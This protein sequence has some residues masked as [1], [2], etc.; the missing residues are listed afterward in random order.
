MDHTTGITVAGSTPSDRTPTGDWKRKNTFLSRCTEVYELKHWKPPALRAPVLILTIAICW[1][2]IAVLEYLLWKCQTDNGLIFAPVIN[3]LPLSDTFLYLYFPTIVAVIFSIYWAWIDLETKRMEPYYQLSKDNGAL[4]KDSLLLQYPFSFL[5]FVPMKAFR[6]R[7]WPVFW[8]SLA[9]VLVTWGLVPTQAGIFSVQTVTRSTNKTFAVSTY[10]MPFEEQATSLTFRYQQSTYGIAALNESLPRYTTRNYTLAPFEPLNQTG[11]SFEGRGTYNGPTTM[12]QL[13]LT[14]EDASRKAVN[15]PDT[16]IFY[17]SSTGCHSMEGLTGNTTMNYDENSDELFFKEFVGR[18]VGY[19]NGGSADWYLSTSCPTT[20]NTTFYAGFGRTKAREEDPPNDVTAI[21]CQT[22]YWRQEVYATIDRQTRMPLRWDPLDDRKPLAWD[23]FNTTNFEALLN[24]GT[25]GVELR[26]D[27]LPTSSIPTYLE[28]VASTNLSMT[29][30]GGASVQ[31]MVGLALATPDRP[32]EDY[33]DWRNLR[34]AYINAYQLLF[35]RAMVDILNTDQPT[36][37]EAT[38]YEEVISEAVVL[39]PVFVHIVVGLLGVVSLAAVALLILSLMHRRNLRTDPSTIASVMSLVADNSLLLSD[40]ADLDCCTKED[41][42]QVLAQKR[43]KLVSDEAGTSILEI[44]QDDIANYG[45]GA[46]ATLGQHRDS[47]KSIAKPVR[48]K[49]FSLWMAFVL[50]TFF[51]ALV[52]ALGVVYA[53]AL[54]NGLP[55]PSSNVI[56]QNILE[57]YIPTAIATLI[58]PIWILINRLLCMLQPL[59]GLQACNARAKE[60]IDANYSSLPPQLVIFKALRTKHFVLAA[61]CAMALLANLLAVA[62]SGLF[63]QALTEIRYETNF[64][65]P[66]LYKVVPINGSIG[67]GGISTKPSGAYQGGLG[68]DQ[69]LIAESNATR[70]TPLPSWT[71]GSLFYLPLFTET[72]DPAKVNSSYFEAT[73]QALGADL[74]CTELKPGKDFGVNMTSVDHS[75]AI[76]MNFT[77]PG[78][79]GKVHCS[80]NQTGTVGSVTSGPLGMRYDCVTG[81]SATE[82]VS[83]VSPR[84]NATREEQEACMGTIALGWIRRASGTCPL[85]KKMTMDGQESRFMRCRPR[86]LTG[87]GKIRVDASGRLQH[88]ARDIALDDPV[89]NAR[90]DVETQS[91]FSNDVINIISQSNFY[92]FREQG[93]AFHNDSFTYDTT[94]Y[95]MRRATNSTRFVDPTRPLPTFDELTGPLNKTYS[96][97]VAIWLGANKRNLFMQAAANGPETIISGHRVQPEQRLFVSTTMFIISQAILCTYVVVAI[98]VYARRPGQYLARL[99]TSI[100]SLIALFA[101]STAIEDMRGT[102][103]LDKKGRA[104]HLEQLDS[105]YGF[106]SFIGRNDGRVHIGIEKVPLVVKPRTKSTWLEQKMPSLRKRSVGVS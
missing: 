15:N 104:R 48:P 33:L 94:N 8:A 28:T 1:S 42:N 73:V 45:H 106:G 100:A 82:F 49:E 103:H 59:E 62:F 67:P 69:F 23:V 11:D 18:Y 44:T 16:R 71:D 4:G 47:P 102:S 29:D 37:K 65:S 12:Y 91:V 54:A 79:T 87:R 66:Y 75:V 90:T 22:H 76:F 101:A 25:L 80:T 14:C 3:E 96:K 105:R 77:V 51:S 32:M 31:P 89:G 52:V 60:S 41:M 92:L 17:N 97:L 64:Q 35:A 83:L 95:F 70:N 9:V 27:A 85:G 19:H 84:E 58:E 6:D 13:D 34:D 68:E 30:G 88:P 55:V 20:A 86:M 74:D 24:S 61:V 78:G 53:K 36:T 39:E 63:N 98:W 46:I 7:H 10:S 26:G 2:L 38:G 72:A 40:F 50:I 5:P 21:F 56:V 99:P 93:I 81:P 57:N 43:Y